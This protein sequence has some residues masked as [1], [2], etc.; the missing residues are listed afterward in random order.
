MLRRVVVVYLGA[1][2]SSC[3]D[4]IKSLGRKD[5]SDQDG[6]GGVDEGIERDGRLQDVR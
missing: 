6:D 2:S 4:M 1:E 5:A 3:A